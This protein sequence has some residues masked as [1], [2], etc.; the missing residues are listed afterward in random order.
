MSKKAKKRS[1]PKTEVQPKEKEG[2]RTSRSPAPCM[3]IEVPV[4]KRFGAYAVDWA[5]GG[6]VTGAPAVLL[7]A[8]VTHRTDFYSDLYVFEALGHSMWWG[9]LAGVLCIF[10]G[11][12]YYVYVPTRIL[13]GQTPGKR[14]LGLEIRRLDGSLPTFGDLFVRYGLV[15]FLVEGSA[16]VTGRF[17]RELVTLITRVDVATPWSIACLAITVVSALLALYRPKHRALHDV[18][19]GTHVVMPSC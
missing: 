19:A 3:T 9:I 2:T 5:L 16:F 4:F 11:L 6:V 12:F 7:Y 17:V 1:R 18:I 15:G 10:A 14:L 8:A 13:P